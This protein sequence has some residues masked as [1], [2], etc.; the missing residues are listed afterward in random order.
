MKRR[1]VGGALGLTIL[2]LT[3][4]PAGAKVPQGQ[5]LVSFGEVECEG[6][7]TVSVFGPRAEGAATA[8]ATSGEHVVLQSF[9]VTFT[10][11][12]GAITTLFSQTFGT[13]SGLT[14]FVC[15]QHFEEPGG[16][17]EITAIV[18]IVPQ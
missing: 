16:T 6:L 2:A 9:D 13:K 4:L 18:A 14:T 5:G 10:D 12:E 1:I 11:T 15:T 17:G 3:A 8:F 7:G